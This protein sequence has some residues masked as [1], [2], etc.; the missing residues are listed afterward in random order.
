MMDAILCCVVFCDVI[1]ANLSPTCA[2]TL[3]FFFETTDEEEFSLSCHAYK[4]VCRL[5][6]GCSFS[7][8]RLCEDGAVIDTP[9]QG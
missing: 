5:L 6:P 2:S 9:K 7:F 8:D 1:L 4:A 3:S